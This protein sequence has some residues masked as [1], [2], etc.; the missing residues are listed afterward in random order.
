MKK[1]V[2][3]AALAGLLV[4]C[5]ER[6]ARIAAAESKTTLVLSGDGRQGGDIIKFCDAGRAIYVVLYDEGSM[7]GVDNAPECKGR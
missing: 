7:W 5:G 3:I 2:I 1:F 6:K 4:G